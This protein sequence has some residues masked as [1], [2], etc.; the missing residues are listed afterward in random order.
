V[1]RYRDADAAIQWLTRAFGCTTQELHR[2]PSGEV[3]HAEARFGANGVGISTAGAVIADN[4]WTAVR[5]G[6]YVCLQEVDALFERARLA[7]AAVA[8]PLN[9]TSYGARDGS[10]RDPGGHLWSVG[11]YPMGSADGAP[12]LFTALHYV[13]GPAAVAFLCNAF[14]F[15]PGTIIEEAGVVH[16]GELRLGRDVL[17]ISSSE[18]ACGF[19]GHDSQCACVCVPDPDAHH[20]KAAAAGAQVLQPPHDT[21]YGARGYYVQDPEG[22]VWGFSNYRPGG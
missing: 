12:S 17:M 19:W 18:K 8:A 22:F 21:A 3:V 9:D 15:T 20:E 16:H 1:L 13:D 14:G 2:A 6:L 7:G 4:P 10:L 5:L 11:T